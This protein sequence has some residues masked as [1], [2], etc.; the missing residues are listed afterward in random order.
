MASS[1]NSKV[2]HLHVL[3]PYSI[4]GITGLH[5][6]IHMLIPPLYT[7]LCWRPVLTRPM[8]ALGPR[9]SPCLLTLLVVIPV[10]PIG[11]FT[12]MKTGTKRK[13]PEPRSAA[14][15]Q[16]RWLGSEGHDDGQGHLVVPG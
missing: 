7:E 9:A 4:H 12:E 3:L 5:G 15:G 16:G 1:Y 2:P 13:R 11:A 6:H 8:L 14:K 10:R